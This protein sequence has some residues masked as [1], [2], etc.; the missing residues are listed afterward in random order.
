MNNRLLLP[1]CYEKRLQELSALN[2]GWDG[3]RASAPD[4]EDLG[5]ARAVLGAF[6][7]GKVDIN[8]NDPWLPKVYAS[9]NGGIDIEWE[10]AELFC[11]IIGDE[12]LIHETRSDP[13]VTHDHF[14]R[15]QN[16]IN[17]L[18]KFLIVFVKERKEKREK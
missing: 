13:F 7:A 2:D 11:A 1:L 12:A 10:K 17:T 5:K 3:D 9:P 14:I 4:D 8:E 15:N 18:G 16:E 6:F